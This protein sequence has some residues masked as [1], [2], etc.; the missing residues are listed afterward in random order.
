MAHLILITTT[1]DDRDELVTIANHLVESRLAACC[2]I[3]SPISS[4]YTWEGKTESAN[5]WVCSIKTL[6]RLFWDVEKAIA[7]LHHYD[8]PQIVA[9]DICEAS[10]GYQQWVSRSVRKP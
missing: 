4:V 1:S 5:E 6:K 2:Q 7:E 9:V 8:E 3:G 10:K